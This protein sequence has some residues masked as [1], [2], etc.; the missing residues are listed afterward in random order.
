MKHFYKQF[1][2]TFCI[3]L[4]GLSA[5]TAQTIVVPENLNGTSSFPYTFIN[6][7]IDAD[8]T[9]TGA[10]RNN[11]YLLKAGGVYYFTAQANWAFDVTLR[12]TGDV[13]LLGKPYVDR[14]NKTGGTALPVLY[15]GTGGFT[16][17]GL[18][19]V[20]GENGAT[21]AAYTTTPI[22]PTS[23]NKKFII[24]NCILEKSRQG[25]MNINGN[26]CSAFITKN[27][28]R[29]FG[30][31]GRLQGNGR[32][33]DIRA[34]FS[35]SIV[36]RDNV[37]HNVLD[38]LHIGFRQTGLNYYEFRS[39]T[40]FNHLGRHGLFQMRNTKKTVIVDNIF[41]NPSMM[42]S[43]PFLADEQ[44]NFRG[45]RNYLVS[46]DTI[47][48]GA[49]FDM[50]S[51]NIFY[52]PDVLNH[53][54]TSTIVT[55]PLILSPEVVQLMKDTSKAY[56]TEVLTLNNIP[57]RA[58][59]LKFAIDAVKFPDSVGLQKMMVEDIFFKGT[60]FDRGYL[61]DFAKF[62]PCIGANTTSYK[63]ATDGGPIGSRFLCT[64]S[65]STEAVAINPYLEF[66][67]EPNPA[68]DYTSFKFTLTKTSDVN[69]TVYDYQGKKVA[70]VF[71]GKKFAGIQEVRWDNLSSLA[72]GMYLANI[73][74][75]EG[76][77]ISKII[78]Q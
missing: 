33:V 35:D 26:G 46:L 58:Q 22:S 68:S 75:A 38:R 19:I 30:D 28:L 21:A 6:D 24:T 47:V 15:R 10:R 55:K 27:I 36:I 65:T 34:T 48:A 53:F 66:D 61:Y 49:S 14:F 64:Y 12:A 17:D 73:Q 32:L 71:E 76:R 54:A 43:S 72:K 3:L 4:T 44:I 63:A 41:M 77:M 31:Y 20:M 56:F 7:Y 78:I 42:G 9:A 18:Y 67:V 50:R 59:V 70:T 11:V 39:N 74:T 37:I 13:K 57:D 40:V 8:T 52:T 62:D 1:L 45:I 51:N 2:F 16:L 29:N 5:V 69:I 25:I 60:A 23:I